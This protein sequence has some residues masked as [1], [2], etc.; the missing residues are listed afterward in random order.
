MNLLLVALILLW[1]NDLSLWSMQVYSPHSLNLCC[2]LPCSKKTRCS[3]VRDIK[4]RLSSSIRTI[5][6]I[7]VTI[8]S[9]IGYALKIWS[10][11]V[12]KHIQMSFKQ[13]FLKKCLFFQLF[14]INV[15]GL[16]TSVHCG[17]YTRRWRRVVS[18]SGNIERLPQH[19]PCSRAAQTKKC[20]PIN[21]DW[22][23]FSV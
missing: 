11:N 18:L 10:G 12:K 5:T 23:T 22:P 14:V 9:V 19:A 20:A 21:T 3:T 1:C 15:L 17:W 13:T 6:L 8:Q 2:Q 7:T 16:G 4:C